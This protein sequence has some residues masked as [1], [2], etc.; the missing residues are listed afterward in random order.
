V[1][2]KDISDEF[3]RLEALV[4]RQMTLPAEAIAFR[5]L[6]CMRFAGQAYE[7][8]VEAP[9]GPLDAG[10]AAQLAARFVAEH[11]RFYGKR[12]GLQ[13]SV[14][15]VTLR[16]AGRLAAAEM[17]QLAG[18]ARRNAPPAERE[19]YFG[20]SVGLQKTPVIGRGALAATSQAGPL[21]VEEYEGT[22]VVPPDCAARLDARGNVIIDVGAST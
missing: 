9:E 15:I 18:A 4:A 2:V 21:I 1:R 13:P 22:I 12:Q 5:H 6:A 19:V 11:D 20:P 7:L 8:T 16:V 17:P 3:Q 10:W 14:E